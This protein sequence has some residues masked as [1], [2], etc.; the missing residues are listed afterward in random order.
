MGPNGPIFPRGSRFV[1]GLP[2]LYGLSCSTRILAANKIQMPFQE[3]MYMKKT[4]IYSFADGDGHDKKLL[5]GK[6]A[7]LCE[8]TQ[9]HPDSS[10]LLRHAW[11]ICKRT[12]YRQA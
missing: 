6:G 4:H 2:Q 5:G 7:N 10:L 8:M 11:I 1:S 3:F 12:S 9:F